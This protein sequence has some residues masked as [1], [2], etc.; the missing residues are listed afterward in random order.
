MMDSS[1]TNQ[2]QYTIAFRIGAQRAK[3]PA[4]QISVNHSLDQSHAGLQ[5]LISAVDWVEKLSVG[6]TSHAYLLETDGLFTQG[7]RPGRTLGESVGGIFEMDSSDWSNG[8]RTIFSIP[9]PT[10]NCNHKKSFVESL[11]PKG[12]VNCVPT[13]RR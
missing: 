3:Y 8:I 2:G 4:N 13:K 5:A 1:L 7:S 6:V 10:L 11:G 9:D 12:G